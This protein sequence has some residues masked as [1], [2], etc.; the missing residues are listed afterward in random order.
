MKPAVMIQM[1]KQVGVSAARLLWSATT[2]INSRSKEIQRQI[3]GFMTLHSAS[4]WGIC[5]ISPRNRPRWLIG[6]RY[7]S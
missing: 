4:A 7:D 2:K 6:A 1:L 5:K 3:M